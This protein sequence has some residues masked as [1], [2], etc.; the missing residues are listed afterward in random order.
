MSSFPHNCLSHEEKVND[1]MKD[2]IMTLRNAKKS[3]N[4][5]AVLCEYPDLIQ[6]S[7]L[8]MKQKVKLVNSTNFDKK[9]ENL[10]F[11]TVC[12]KH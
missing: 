2:Q 1:F 10:I 11:F 6:L 7:L 3:A 12:I 8:L 9:S 4:G 5:E